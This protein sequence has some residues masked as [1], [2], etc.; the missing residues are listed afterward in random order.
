MEFPFVG[1]QAVI[2]V[3]QSRVRARPRMVRGWQHSQWGKGGCKEVGGVNVLDVMTTWAGPLQECTASSIRTSLATSGCGLAGIKQVAGGQTTDSCPDSRR[4]KALGGR[5]R[6]R[7][8]EK[9]YSV[10]AE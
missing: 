4:R 3:A 7:S 1:P 5:S 2:N 6:T 9:T 10:G 8:A